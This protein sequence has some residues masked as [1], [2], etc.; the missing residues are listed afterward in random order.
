MPVRDVHD[1]RLDLGPSARLMNN[2]GS[3]VALD[4]GHCQCRLS[5]HALS[6]YKKLFF[7]N[8]F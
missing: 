6:F 5:I 4:A 3:Y 8:S 7:Y 1:M 2:N